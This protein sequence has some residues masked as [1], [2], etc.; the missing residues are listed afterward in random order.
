[1]CNVESK[2]LRQ[3]LFIGHGQLG[4][5]GPL[6]PFRNQKLWPAIIC[7]KILLI[8]SLAKPAVLCLCFPILGFLEVSV[9][10]L[11]SSCG[12]CC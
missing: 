3:L 11:P 12:I 2:G 1:M 10:S 6:I 8:S 4:L 9:I 5:D 7:L